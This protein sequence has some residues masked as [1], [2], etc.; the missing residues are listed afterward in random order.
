[1]KLYVTF[2]NHIGVWRIADRYP[3]YPGGLID[4]TENEYAEYKAVTEKWESWQQKIAH[5]RS[6]ME[7]REVHPVNEI[8]F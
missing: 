2:A 6:P 1:M 8:P 7:K 3:D 5:A 4:V